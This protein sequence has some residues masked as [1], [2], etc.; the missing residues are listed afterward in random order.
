MKQITET[1]SQMDGK[2]KY[3]ITNNILCN[4]IETNTYHRIWNRQ[5]NLR[6][7][8]YLFTKEKDKSCL[9]W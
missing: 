1:Y 6:L 2:Y 7:K 8:K 4:I 9:C 3:H 5:N